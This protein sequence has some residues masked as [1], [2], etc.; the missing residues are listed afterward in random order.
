MATRNKIITNYRDSRTNKGTFNP[1]DL[2][3]KNF[4]YFTPIKFVRSEK[5]KGSIWLFECKCGKRLERSANYVLMRPGTSCGCKKSSIISRQK[6]LPDNQAIKNTAYAIHVKRCEKIGLENKLSKEH[7]I[8]IASKSC[9]YCGDFSFR[10]NS[11][12]NTR[13]PFNSVDRKNNEPFYDEINSVPACFICQM[14]KR[15]LSYEFFLEHIKK[16]REHQQSLDHSRQT[17]F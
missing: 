13:I 15:D 8:E 1:I 2:K 14:M 10:K 11:N 5:K 7:Y 6:T 17:S 9:E 4:E 12:L 16:I 3:D